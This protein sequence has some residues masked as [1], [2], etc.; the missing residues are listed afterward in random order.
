MSLK[1]LRKRCEGRLET[2]TL[3]TPFTAEAFCM[4]LAAQMKSPINLIAIATNGNPY[5]AWIRVHSSDYIFYE[6]HTTPLHQSH[7]ILHEA[8]HILCDHQGV[9][10]LDTDIASL[11][12]SEVS[13][14]TVQ[15][16]MGRNT[17]TSAEEQEAE[18]LATLIWRRAMME[19][20]R[21]AASS[22]PDARGSLVRLTA[23]LEGY[24]GAH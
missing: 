22:Q 5:G 6:G 21:V 7:I 18:L 17:Y 11:L 1:A 13:S 10:F 15:R 9:S 4:E 16:M 12:I 3:P 19:N 24:A 2:I 23:A 14:Q 20:L 8:C